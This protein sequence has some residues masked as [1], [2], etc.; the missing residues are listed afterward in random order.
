M[1]NSEQPINPTLLRQVGHNEYRVVSEKDSREGMLLSSYLGLTKREYFAAM[2]MQGLL[3][4]FNAHGYYGNSDHHPCVGHIA[5][6]CAD[7]LLK[8]IEN[9]N[10]K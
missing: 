3:V 2:A 5:V 8:A 6:Q 1:K 7:E 10:T 9:E 4:N